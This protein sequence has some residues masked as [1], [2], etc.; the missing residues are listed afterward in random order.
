M[1]VDRVGDGDADD[2]GTSEEDEEVEEE[3]VTSPVTDEAAFGPID[4]IVVAVVEAKIGVKN[5]Q[6]KN[7]KS[8]TPEPTAIV[9]LVQSNGDRI[10]RRRR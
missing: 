4:V 1:S 3:W 9:D 2:D 8:R 6:K 5:Q 10:R 7:N